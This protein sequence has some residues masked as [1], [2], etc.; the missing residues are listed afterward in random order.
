MSIE[1]KLL[2]KLQPHADRIASGNGNDFDYLPAVLLQVVEGQK[3]HVQ[4]VAD[5]ATTVARKLDETEVSISSVKAT[6]EQ[7]GAIARRQMDLASEAT[8]ERLGAISRQ[9]VEVAQKAVAAEA[10][11][12]QK[13]VAMEA[14]VAALHAISQKAHRKSHYLLFLA[15]VSIAVSI[16]LAAVVV[17]RH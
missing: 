8:N 7:V 10:A 3:R 2:T 15:L 6:S 5:A 1:Q 12:T 13:S 4:A 16:C 17:L 9:L 14:S 11:A